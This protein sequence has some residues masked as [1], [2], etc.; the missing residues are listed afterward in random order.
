MRRGEVTG[1]VG[2][3]EREGG[4]RGRGREGEDY[5]IHI[6]RLREVIKIKM[7]IRSRKV[8]IGKNRLEG[9]PYP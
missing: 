8:Y 2:G 5:Y 7:L 4:G 9:E 3:E 1:E 6:F